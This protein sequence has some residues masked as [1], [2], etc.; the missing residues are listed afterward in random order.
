MEKT[1]RKLIKIQAILT[2][3]SYMKDGGLS[4]GF[5]TQEMSP[6]DKVVMAELYQTFGWLAFS[7]NQVDT[8][9]MPTEEAE[10]KQKTP[11]KRLRS[12][13][14]VFAKQRGIKPE[15]FEAWYRE[16]MEKIIERVKTK[17]D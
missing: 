4:L 11:S 12:V 5:S 3:I 14:Y 16:Q 8:T 10:D 6:E 13:L 15:N 9:D 17:L 2:R 1:D 7:P